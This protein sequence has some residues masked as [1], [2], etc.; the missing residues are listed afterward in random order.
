LFW[1]KLA[2]KKEKG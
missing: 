2:V 1:P